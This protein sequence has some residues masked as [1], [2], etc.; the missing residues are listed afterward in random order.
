MWFRRKVQHGNKLGR[1]IGFPTLNLNVGGAMAQV[2]AGVYAC[3]VRIHQRWYKGAMHLGPKMG[4][5]APA[6]EIFVLDFNTMIYG[7]WITVRVGK[8]IRNLMTFSS[9][10]ALKKQIEDDVKKVL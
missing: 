5:Q 4:G 8:K 10:D 6:F 2:G 3:E 7:E 1:T 9:V